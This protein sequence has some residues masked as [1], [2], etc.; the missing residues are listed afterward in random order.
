MNFYKSKVCH[1]ICFN[2]F[3]FFLQDKSK[4]VTYVLASGLTYGLGENIFH[5]LF[6]DA[7]HGIVPYLQVYGDGQ[8]F[9]PTIHIMDLAR[10]L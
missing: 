7:W 9:V 3:L 5:F 10:Y 1:I 8:N 4:F 6:K 2:K